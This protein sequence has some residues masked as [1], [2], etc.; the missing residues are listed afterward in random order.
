MAVVDRVARLYVQ[1]P[2]S[3]LLVATQPTAVA[4]LILRVTAIK[5][6]MI[7]SDSQSGC[8]MLSQVACVQQ[9]AHYS[10]MNLRHPQRQ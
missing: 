6:S 9:H 1:A 4:R 2:S 8:N 10:C 5:L 7:H 3:V